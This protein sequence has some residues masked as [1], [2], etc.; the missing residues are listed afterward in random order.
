MNIFSLAGY[1]LVVT[2]GTGLLVGCSTSG[3]PSLAPAGISSAGMDAAHMT[4]AAMS[5]GFWLTAA[6]PAQ[7]RGGLAFPNRKHHKKKEPYQYVSD[8]GTDTLFAFDYPKTDSSI[9]AI[10]NFVVPQ[11]EC[12]KNGKKTFWVADTG[13]AHIQEFKAGGSLPINTLSESVGLVVGCA[14][15]PSTGDL[16]ATIVSNGDV[17]VFPHATEPA[18]TYSTEL[19]QAYFDGY[20][21]KDN[22]FADGF[23]S[24]TVVGLVELPKGGSS[25]QNISVS[26]TIEFPGNVQ[27]DGKYVTVND[28]NT[29]E[30]YR[31]SLSGTTA[32]LKG[33]V[34]L[35]GSKDC[36]QTWI[37][38]SVVY[39]P[40]AG[41]ANIKVYKYPA[42]GNPIANLTGGVRIPVGAVK[43][44]N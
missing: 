38:K 20:D 23:I 35:A 14:V 17:I 32:T 30:I 12:T 8:V 42:G 31:Y 28:Q 5:N 27:W 11:G 18:T 2:A 26:N 13:A 44:S 37:A 9:G 24:Q 25:F 19:F 34:K 15:D 39:C 1:A 7:L 33:I 40:D 4:K 36:D 21:N 10:K 3:A 6:H 22:L 43:V 41:A 16:A 29:H